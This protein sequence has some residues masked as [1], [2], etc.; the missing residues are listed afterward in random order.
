[1]E[2]LR[3]KLA[4][5]HSMLMNLEDEAAGGAGDDVIVTEN[6]KLS[7]L[8]THLDL[9]LNQQDPLQ[10]ALWDIA[11][12]IYKTAD[13]KA[14]EELDAPFIAAGRAVLKAEWEKVKAEMQGAEFQHENLL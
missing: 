1:M 5:Y 11:D 4:E 14:R 7:E 12:R 9:L 6:R 3:N 2:T 10:K 13:Q 8:G